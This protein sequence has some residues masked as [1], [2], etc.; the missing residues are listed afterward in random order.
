MKNAARQLEE[1]E[2]AFAGLALHALRAGVPLGPTM[3]RH[4]HAFD[5]SPKVPRGSP[6]YD[7]LLREVIND[8]RQA[9]ID[10]GIGLETIRSWGAIPMETVL[11]EAEGMLADSLRRST[12]NGG[13]E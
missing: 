11:V 2:A 1:L 13:S 3:D 4:F 5:G 12:L 8:L 10:H 7:S 6:G 9:A